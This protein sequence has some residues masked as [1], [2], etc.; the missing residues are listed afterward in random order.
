L[1]WFRNIKIEP[2]DYIEVGN[3]HSNKSINFEVEV[4]SQ[5]E[6][7]NF[8][9][10]VK[11]FEADAGLF[12]LPLFSMEFK[13]P[14]AKNKVIQ[15][16]GI[17]SPAFKILGHLELKVEVKI[18]R[19]KFDCCSEASRFDVKEE[20]N[21]M[22]CKLLSDSK[23]S[24]F[25]YIIKDRMFKVH[26]CILAAS[27]RFFDN[28]FSSD[29]WT[30]SQTNE[31]ISNEVDPVIF[32]HMLR[33]I[34]GA[35]LPENFAS[36]SVELF[37][38]AHFYEIEGLKKVCEHEILN[39]LSVDNAMETYEMAFVYDIDELKKTAWAIIM[40]WVDMMMFF[41]LFEYRLFLFYSDILKNTAE[42]KFQKNQKFP[43]PED[44]RDILE[45]QNKKE[46]LWGSFKK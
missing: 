26:K 17:E 4:K 9:L 2:F 10:K 40:Q 11:V 42:I 19:A 28:M 46:K 45:L 23:Y 12:G 37:K 33:F 36:T 16:K 44:I 41:L 43:N 31:A 20:M 3:V 38:L 6:P 13:V 18:K 21:E 25:T 35:K 27:S 34:Y 22:G 8:I 14:E 5:S 30:E 15:L 24:D 32:E 39:K 1:L 7:W 29:F